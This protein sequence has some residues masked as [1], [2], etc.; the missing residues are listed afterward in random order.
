MKFLQHFLQQKTAAKNLPQSVIFYRFLIHGLH[1]LIRPRYENISLLDLQASLSQHRKLI[2]HDQIDHHAVFLL[3]LIDGLADE[4]IVIIYKDLADVTDI[5]ELLSRI[6]VPG[7]PFNEAG[8][9]DTGGD[10]YSTHTQ[11]RKDDGEYRTCNGHRIDITIADGQ[12]RSNA[13][14]ESGERILEHLRL[15]RMLRIVHAYASRQHQHEDDEKR[16]QYLPAL[17]LDDRSDDVEGIV[18]LVQPEQMQDPY[19][20]QHSEYHHSREEEY[21]KYGEKTYQAIKGN[22]EFHS[23]LRTA[24]CRIQKIRSPDPQNILNAEERSGHDLNYHE[25]PVILVELFKSLQNDHQYVQDD[26]GHQ[27][28][29]EYEARGIPFFAYLDYVEYFFLHGSIRLS[30]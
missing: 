25:E 3:D 27:N 24:V 6:G 23:G 29:V 21:R 30:L 17:L 4:L 28:I 9:D 14:P 19:H 8:A 5:C 15:S 2:P 26:V 7:E 20:P 13:P 18:L 12:Y 1:D 11:E 22:D 10:C 16:R